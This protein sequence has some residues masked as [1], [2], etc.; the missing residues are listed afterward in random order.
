VLPPGTPR[1]RVQL[2]RKAFTDT[3][4]DP[5]FLAEAQKAKLDINSETGK[6]LEQN[7]KAVFNLEPALIAKLKEILFGK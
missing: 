5:E 3:L 7:V 1:E 2:L 4:K 6:E